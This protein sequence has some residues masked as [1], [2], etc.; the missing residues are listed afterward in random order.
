VLASLEKTGRLLVAQECVSMG[1]PGE[2]VLAAAAAHGIT[3]KGS[4]VCSCGE[5]FVPH[6]TITQLRALCG[7]DVESLYQKA[8][9][10]MNDGK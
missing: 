4:A 5:D 6:G 1:A 7:L 8:R 3:L 9:E 10:V 2:D